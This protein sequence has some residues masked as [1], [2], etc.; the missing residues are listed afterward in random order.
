MNIKVLFDNVLMLPYEAPEMSEGGI[1]LSDF[2]KRRPIEGLVVS[3]GSNVDNISVGDRVIY[4]EYT[5]P[6]T[7]TIEYLGEEREFYLLKTG[8]I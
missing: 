5:K 2:S 1:I 3:I 8:A 4:E 6:Q 7:I